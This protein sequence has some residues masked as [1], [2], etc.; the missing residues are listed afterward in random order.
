MCLDLDSNPWP[1]EQDRAGGTG[2]AEGAAAPPIFWNFKG[3]RG[4][5]VCFAPPIIWQSMF[6]PLNIKTITTSL[7]LSNENHLGGRIHVNKLFVILVREN[8]RIMKEI[9]HFAIKN[10][11][12][13]T[14]GNSAELCA[15]HLFMFTLWMPNQNDKIAQ[16]S[17]ASKLRPLPN[18][19][20]QLL[21]WLSNASTPSELMMRRYKS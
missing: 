8:W 6:C 18:R 2:G 11:K 15:I 4:K 10:A 20:K 21:L 7:I 17:W 12:L 16:P 1:P 13:D 14:S 5:I 9:S 19:G 3:K